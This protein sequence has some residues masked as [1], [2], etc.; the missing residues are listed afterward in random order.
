MLIC[1]LYRPPDTSRRLERNFESDFSD[2]IN[3]S[4]SE[5]EQLILMGD[6]GAEYLNNSKH[7][8]SKQK[9]L[10]SNR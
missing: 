8:E 6:W 4:V 9:E 2:M 10:D 1:I 5:N 3:I 7:K